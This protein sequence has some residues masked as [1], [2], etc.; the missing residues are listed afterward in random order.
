M[1]TTSGRPAS[2]PMSAGSPRRARRSGLLVGQA[3]ERPEPSAA[4]VARHEQRGDRL[5]G[6][7]AASLGCPDRRLD[8]LDDGQKVMPSP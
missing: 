5:A 1:T 3:G 4:V 2:S 6:A 7:L 8:E